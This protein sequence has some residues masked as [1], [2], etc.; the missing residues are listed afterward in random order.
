MRSGND[1][2]GV[3]CRGKTAKRMTP[4]KRP[5]GLREAPSSRLFA[6][7]LL[8]TLTVSCGDDRGIASSSAD[9]SGCRMQV[10]PIKESAAF[11]EFGAL[12]QPSGIPILGEAV[13]QATLQIVDAPE[14]IGGLPVS[15]MSWDRS[16][17][18]FY[19]S[20]DA[21]VGK[22]PE[23]ATR[24]G[25]VTLKVDRYEDKV[26]PVAQILV[27]V[28]GDRAVPVQVGNFAGAITFGDPDRAGIREHHLAWGD[29]TT[30]WELIAVRPPEDLVALGRAVAC[31]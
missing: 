7:L 2:R 10:S 17:V 18:A 24:H 20:D 13:D 15:A 25:G 26:T 28:L 12:S 23:V 27:E 5:E 1:P 22:D 6:V 3:P 19:Y 14:S 29:E 31:N 16:E 30:G 21:L 4:M 8:A 9:V 11:I